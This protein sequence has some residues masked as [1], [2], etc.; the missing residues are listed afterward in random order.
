MNQGIID[1]TSCVDGLG[2]YRVG[3]TDTSVFY[4]VPEIFLFQISPA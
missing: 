4:Y 1:I 2:E 3:D